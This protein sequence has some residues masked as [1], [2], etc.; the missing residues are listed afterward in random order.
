MGD[1]FGAAPNNSRLKRCEYRGLRLLGAAALLCAWAG[2][3]HCEPSGMARPLGPRGPNSA[4]ALDMP[5]PL[6]P[7]GPLATLGVAPKRDRLP[8]ET[9][10]EVKRFIVTRLVPRAQP[11]TRLGTNC[12]ESIYADLCGTPVAD[13]K[14]D[15]LLAR[16]LKK[17]NHRASVF[18]LE[19]VALQVTQHLRQQ[20]HLLDTAFVPPQTVAGGVV[21]IYVLTGRLGKVVPKGNKRYSNEV[22]VWPFAP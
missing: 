18:D 17:A 13:L 10:V 16:F 4:P 21:N 15:A 22:L 12:R 1:A 2:A 7:Q 11:G 14:L 20:D 6:E 3:V 5:L 19:D 8:D 9:Q